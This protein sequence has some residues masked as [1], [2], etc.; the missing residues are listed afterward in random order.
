ME[1]IY[2]SYAATAKGRKLI[3]DIREGLRISA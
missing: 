3:K 2:S 1:R